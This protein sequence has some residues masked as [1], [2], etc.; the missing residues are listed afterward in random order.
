MAKYQQLLTNNQISFGLFP[1]NI[2]IPLPEKGQNKYCVLSR[3][4]RIIPYLHA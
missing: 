3:F 1:A 2:R 4:F